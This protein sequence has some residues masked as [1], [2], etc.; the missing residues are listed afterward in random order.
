MARIRTPK[1]M[2]ALIRDR[3]R[4]LRMDQA[5]LAVRVGV[6]RQ[7]VLEVEKGKPRAAM[8]LVLR[9]LEALGVALLASDQPGSK[10]AD[11]TAAVD[12]IIA[13]ARTRRP[14]P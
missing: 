14:K 11:Y 2:G 1:D 10:Q 8:G 12:D 13:T 7:W 4:S 6:S 3:R 5:A 9:T